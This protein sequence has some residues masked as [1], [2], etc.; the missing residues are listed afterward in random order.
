MIFSYPPNK[1]TDL[2][3]VFYQELVTFSRRH[4]LGEFYTNEE[5]RVITGSFLE[6]LLTRKIKGIQYGRNKIKIVKSGYC[7]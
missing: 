1:V 4:T 5:D 3:N 6:K 2:L 7:F